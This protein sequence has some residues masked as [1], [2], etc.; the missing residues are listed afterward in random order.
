M[1]VVPWEAGGDSS[2]VLARSQ[3]STRS[4]RS[5]TREIRQQYWPF[6]A[7]GSGSDLLEEDPTF[8]HSDLEV[9]VAQEVHSEQA[10]DVMAEICD[11]CVHVGHGAAEC[12]ELR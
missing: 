4:A 8:C 11:V 3:S 6:W 12:C 1:E 7:T 9:E 2:A 10:V 5:T